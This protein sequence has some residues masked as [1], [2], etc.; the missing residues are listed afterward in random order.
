M[1]ILGFFR[2][3]DKRWHSLDRALAESFSRVKSETSLIFSWLHYFREKD[4]VHDDRHYRAQQQIQNHGNEIQ[5]MKEEILALKSQI[6]HIKI[7]SEKAKIQAFS[8]SFPNL[9]RTKSEPRS[10]P[11]ARGVFERN[12][13]AKIR[14]QK[15][16][17]VMD[18]ILK[19]VEKGMHST[20]EIE[21]TI[22]KE[23]SLCGRTAFYDYLRELKHKK[24]IKYNER[25]QKRIVIM[26]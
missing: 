5:K 24:L 6:L 16:D 1:G 23:K 12:I 21:T 2:K 20:K 17:Y 14:H 25:G 8:G 26:A 15:K 10:E 11:A 19:L 22:V 4:K 18:Q 7:S 3:V 13:L 9:V